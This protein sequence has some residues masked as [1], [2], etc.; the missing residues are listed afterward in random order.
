MDLSPLTAWYGQ[1]PLAI[2]VFA[3]VAA[4]FA[5]GPVIGDTYIPTPVKALLAL[6]V[7]AILFPIAMATQPVPAMDL[8]FLLLLVKETLVGLSMGFFVS[9]FFNGVRFGGELI[10]RYAGFAAAE[11]FDP[12]TNASVTPVG[13]VMHLLLVLLFLTLNGHHYFF[14]ALDRSYELVPLGGYQITPAFQA[15]LAAGLDEMSTIAVALSFPVLAAVMAITAAEGVVTRAIPQINIMHVSFAVKIVVSL[16]VMY[17]GL[18]SAVVFL[19][20]VLGTM[21]T[22]GYAVIGTLG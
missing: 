13:D 20:T 18:P 21:Q 17:A 11:N 2:L 6:A 5:V 3:R 7:T 12:D 14:A 19:G 22:A 9:L 8:W 10:N 16:M 15:A 4:L 1:L